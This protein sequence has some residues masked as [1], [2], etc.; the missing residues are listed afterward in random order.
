MQKKKMSQ[1]IRVHTMC[2]LVSVLFRSLAFLHIP[3]SG[4]HACSVLAR[5]SRSSQRRNTI[6]S[7]LRHSSAMSTGTFAILSL[8]LYSKG[9]NRIP[10]NKNQTTNQCIARMAYYSVEYSTLSFENLAKLFFYELVQNYR[11]RRLH[12]QTVKREFQ[13]G[14]LISSRS[15]CLGQDDA[16]RQPPW[17]LVEVH[18]KA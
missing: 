7:S 2:V 14:L 11:P 10:L 18:T 13:S 4:S 9:K 12:K 16:T 1:R 17:R 3:S 8:S 5:R 15:H 6:E